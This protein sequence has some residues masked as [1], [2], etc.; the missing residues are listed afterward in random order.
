ME[1][2]SGSSGQQKRIPVPLV[3]IATVLLFAV[4]TVA[5]LTTQRPFVD[6]AAP[7]PL[8]TA[9]ITGTNG[10]LAEI[11][12]WTPTA[13]L[14]TNLPVPVELRFRD[15][16][17][18][19]QVRSAQNRDMALDVSG[20]EHRNG[21]GRLTAGSSN[22]VSFTSVA[23]IPFFSVDSYTG[24]S[25]PSLPLGLRPVFDKFPYL[26]LSSFDIVTNAVTSP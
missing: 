15:R 21:H 11:W 20:T 24:V 22:S 19:L 14:R 18:L 9:S 1:A 16:N 2:G 17:L 8:W 25:P 26:I 6:I 23:R 7:R 5:K 13:T 4:M 3:L 10:D 12:V